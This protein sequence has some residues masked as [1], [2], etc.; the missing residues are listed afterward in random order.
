VQGDVKRVLEPRAFKTRD[1]RASWVRNI[2]IT[3]GGDDLNVVLWG[4]KALLPVLPGTSI[5]IYHATAK[6]GRFHEIELGAGRTSA[7]RIP[8]MQSIE[9]VFEGTVITSNGNTFIDNGQ[10]RYL[11]DGGD[12]PPW[13]EMRV[14]GVLSGDRI[15]PDHTE[16]V[17]VS[18]DEIGRKVKA[19]QDRVTR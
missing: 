17:N 16:P 11:I 6:P 4:E 9:I 1:G 2:V 13:H 7:I 5:E 10:V 15:R 14:K 19:L 12:L 8:D 3:D 18:P